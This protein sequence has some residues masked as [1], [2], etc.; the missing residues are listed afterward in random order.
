MDVDLFRAGAAFDAF[1][2]VDMLV[3][4]AEGFARHGNAGQL[5]RPE[6]TQHH[7]QREAGDTLPKLTQYRTEVH[8]FPQRHH[9]PFV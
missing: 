7:N 4:S 2:I 3:H 6:H 8:I 9:R 1:R 5:Q